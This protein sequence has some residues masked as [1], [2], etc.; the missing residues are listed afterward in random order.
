MDEIGDGT[1]I[2]FHDEAHRS[3]HIRPLHET[4]QLRACRIATRIA[5]YL[6]R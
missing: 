4:L 2:V 6:L 1:R 3:L 5:R